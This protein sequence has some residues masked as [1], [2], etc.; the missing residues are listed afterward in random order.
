MRH[1]EHRAVV[2]H[3]EILQ[4]DDARKVE[5]VRRLVEQDDVRVAE[6]RLR[7]QDFHLEARIHVGH[8]G[9]VILRRYAEALQDAGRIRL[10]L[11][12]AEIGKLLLELGGTDA[13]LVRHLVLGVD[14]V[15]LLAAVVQALVAHDDRV[16]DGIGIVHRLILLE[17]GHSGLGV[18]IDAAGAR[19]E[20]AGE[21]LQERGLAGAV[22][23]DDTVAVAGGK[24]QVHLG[25]QRGSAVL[26]R[27]V[28]NSDHFGNSF[29]TI[30]NKLVYHIFPR[31][32]STNKQSRR[33]SADSAFRLFCKHLF[34]PCIAGK[35]IFQRNLRHT[36][37]ERQGIVDK[38][39]R[40][41][42]AI[43]HDPFHWDFLF[44]VCDIGERN[45]LHAAGILTVCHDAL[46]RDHLAGLAGERRL[47]SH[48]TGG[49]RFVDI[50]LR[51]EMRARALQQRQL[52]AA[53]FRMFVL[54]D[55]L[56]QTRRQTAELRM[57]EAVGR[58]GL[59]LGNE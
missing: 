31:L 43:R 39:L 27:E 30:D 38:V 2:I 7:Q 24:L 12:A 44:I 14:G 56:R 49:K 40:D 34:Q 42:V 1:D 9:L 25:K 11:P 19:L 6:E 29:V 35:A 52:N 54:L 16:H 18:N 26:Q 47:D 37:N 50:R 4:P 36:L 22:G 8:H 45:E 15:L 20:L 23:A 28:I 21:D 17:D 32:N 59:G 33:F 46:K 57:A 58:G 3:Q 48:L 53:H 5:I 13:V 55:H 10:R 51:G 41:V